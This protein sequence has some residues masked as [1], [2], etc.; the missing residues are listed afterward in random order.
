MKT[1][2]I[3]LANGRE[4]QVVSVIEKANRIISL[5]MSK[6]EM[7]AIFNDL[8]TDNLR[9]VALF[10]VDDTISSTIQITELDKK[11]DQRLDSWN[12]I[13][14]KDGYFCDF[15]L[16]DLP[17]PTQDRLTQEIIDKAKAYDILMGLEVS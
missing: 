9:E 13:V 16:T 6:E 1:R 14:E 10:E 5:C 11:T 7:L 2:K 15:T 4:I 8:T 3:L 17:K 12:A